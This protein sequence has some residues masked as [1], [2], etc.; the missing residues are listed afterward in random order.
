MERKQIST[1]TIVCPKCNGKGYIQK[2]ESFD[3]NSIEYADYVC[4][5]CKGH[6]VVYESNYIEYVPVSEKE[7]KLVDLK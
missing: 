5:T 4:P 6:R 1:T 2:S 7:V 3:E